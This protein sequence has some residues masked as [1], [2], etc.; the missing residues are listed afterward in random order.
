LAIR[1]P[2][3][4]DPGRASMGDLGCAAVQP[5]SCGANEARKPVVMI[6]RQTLLYLPAQLVGPLFQ[7]VAVLA[8]THWLL[9]TDYGLIA[10]IFALQELAFTLCMSWWTHYTIR[11]LPGLPDRGAYA[12]SEFTMLALAAAGQVPVVLTALWLTSHLGSADLLLATIAFTVSRALNTH[13]GERARALGDVATYTIVQMAGPVLGFG[14]GLALM[15]VWHGAAAVLT[16][17]AIVQ[18]AILPLLAWRLD[19]RLRLHRPIDRALLRAALR[20]GGPLLAAGGFGWICLNGIRLVVEHIDGLA[21]VGLLSVGWNLGQRLIAVA[22]MLVTAAAFPLAV[23]E[24]AQ[25]G[26]EAGVAYIGRTAPLIIGILMPATIGLVIVSEP[27][28]R[29][30]V[31]AEFQAATLIVLPLATIGAAIR[32]LRMHTVDQ[33]FMIAE[34][35]GFLLVLNIIEAAATTVLSIV[36]LLLGG[37]GGACLGVVVATALSA[38]YGLAVARF[39]HGFSISI[40]PV[41]RITAAAGIMAGIVLLDIYPDGVLGLAVQIAA[42]GL[43]YL[44]LAILMLRSLIAPHRRVGFNP[45]A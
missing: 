31:G 43:V 17:F 33:V 40:E 41:I 8:W 14:L 37:L 26:A 29:S 28:T 30:F 42:G 32:N 19:L 22:A 24:T 15:P 3:L 35:P 2:P 36:G 13:L 20:Y 10:L 5:A 21:Q 6:L 25:R 16:G 9:P 27:L 45:G 7:F 39:R 4:D 38:L 23:G 12:R 44:G 11:Y 1:V 34:R 18:V